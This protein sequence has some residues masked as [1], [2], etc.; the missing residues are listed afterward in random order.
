MSNIVDNLLLKASARGTVARTAKL[1]QM[2]RQD[3]NNA[4]CDDLTGWPQGEAVA[5]SMYQT[6]SSG[7]P[8]EDSVTDWVAEVNGNTLINMKLTSGNNRDYDTLNTVV[9][10]NFTSE[11]AN[12]LI[13]ALL[14]IHNQDGT[15]KLGQIDNEHL[16]DGAVDNKKI[17]LKGIN[18]DRLADNSVD[19]RVLSSG[20]V[21][22]E[23][24]NFPRACYSNATINA[25]HNNGDIIRLRSKI[26]DNTADI[27]LLSDSSFKIKKTGVLVLSCN[28]WIQATAAARPWLTVFRIRGRDSV[29]VA[30]C[31]SNTPSSYTNLTLANHMITVQANDIIKLTCSVVDGGA[32]TLDGASG[33]TNSQ[34]VMEII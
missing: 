5:L 28:L 20:A 14:K 6:D 23:H 10:I 34:V 7:I 19:G 2:K 22:P 30:D 27:E 31:I 11:W 8:D 16:V 21:K 26:Y 33:R 29:A 32:F 1:Q 12:R 15:L 9:T 3:N 13:E 25:Q 4:I 24:T 17:K 18:G